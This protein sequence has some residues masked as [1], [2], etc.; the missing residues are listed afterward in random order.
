MKINVLFFGMAAE[1]AG[2]KT[3]TISNI[4]DTNSLKTILLRDYPLLNKFSFSL[5]VE[6]KII[7]SNTRLKEGDAIAVLPPFSGG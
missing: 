2:K 1:A 4:L 3:A 7:N 5:A 6:K